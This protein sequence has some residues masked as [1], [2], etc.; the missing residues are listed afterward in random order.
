MLLRHCIN[1]RREIYLYST[2][3]IVNETIFFLLPS[4]DYLEFKNQLSILN[5]TK[6]DMQEVLIYFFMDAFIPSPF[7]S[8]YKELYR[9]YSAFAKKH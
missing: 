4:Q 2:W 3:S 7:L 9:T 8:F 1:Y 5:F 6:K